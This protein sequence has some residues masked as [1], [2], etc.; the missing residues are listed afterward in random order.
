MMIAVL[1]ASG[2]IGSY[3]TAYLLCHSEENIKGS[4]YSKTFD[5]R[6]FELFFQPTQNL[7][8]RIHN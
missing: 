4:Y 6:Q 1:G 8:S 3:L 2:V 7:L 5:I